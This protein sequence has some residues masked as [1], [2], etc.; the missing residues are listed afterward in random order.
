MC[1]AKRVDSAS[2]WTRHSAAIGYTVRISLQWHNISRYHRAC[3]FEIISDGIPAMIFMYPFEVLC[4]PV[5]II[6]KW[7]MWGM[8]DSLTQWTSFCSPVGLWQLLRRV[9][10]RGLQQ[11]QL[12]CYR[13]RQRWRDRWMLDHCQ[14][15]PA[16]GKSPLFQ[17]QWDRLSRR[18]CGGEWSR[19]WFGGYWGMWHCSVTG[20]KM[21]AVL[22]LFIS[23]CWVEI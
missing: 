13:G 14:E 19:R 8:Q 3:N 4:I 21:S 11:G 9:Q 12:S 22:R 2:R 1:P 18:H 6:Y 23:A 15:R 17:D 7:A 16:T 10:H 5:V 20:S